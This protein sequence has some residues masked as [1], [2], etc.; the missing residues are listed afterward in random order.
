MKSNESGIAEWRRFR[1]S[2]LSPEARPAHLLVKGARTSFDASML[3]KT[4]R[5][6]FPWKHWRRLIE[7]NEVDD[8]PRDSAAPG[9]GDSQQ[10]ANGRGRRQEGQQSKR[11]RATGRVRVAGRSP[12]PKAEAN[13]AN[14]WDPSKVPVAL[15]GGQASHSQG[16][17]FRPAVVERLPVERR[18]ARDAHSLHSWP[19]L[20][21]VKA[22]GRPRAP[23]RPGG[24]RESSC[25]PKCAACSCY[26]TCSELVRRQDC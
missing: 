24:L 20:G 26:D 6:D 11:D 18:C 1:A 19:G 12:G 16:K 25:F 15:L 7:I 2:A 3:R 23:R 8:K 10:L 22:K 4:R 13:P 17:S 14:N 5:A 9:I 21:T